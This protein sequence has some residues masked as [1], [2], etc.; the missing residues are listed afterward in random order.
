M[1]Q[2]AHSL[3]L[4]ALLTASALATPSGLN[5]IPTTDTVPHRTV[6]VQAFSSFGGANQ[7]AANGPGQHAF[8]TGFKTGWDFSPMHLEWGMDSPIGTDQSGPLFFQTKARF[9]PWEGGMF[10][11]GVANVALT[12]TGRA[13]DPFTYAMLSHDFELF[14]FHAGYGLQTNGN[15]FLFGIDRNFKVFE[16]NLNLNADLVQ[17]RD[18]RGT[19]TA[20]GAKYD[21]S[22][23]IVLESWLNIPDREEVSAIAKIN[24]VFTF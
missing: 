22:K 3:A 20:L 15:S 23:H 4:Y 16:R 17:T 21:L 19:I 5:N 7:F 8:W 12:D 10:V 18:G 11:L 9:E 13:S 1:K 6:A 14:R 24:F 2:H